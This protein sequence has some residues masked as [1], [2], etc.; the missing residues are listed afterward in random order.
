MRTRKPTA[1]LE[2]SGAFIKDPQRRRPPE[3]VPTAPLGGPPVHLDE[4]EQAIW[5]EL[6]AILPPGVAGNTDRP[7]FELVSCLLAQ[8]RHFRGTMSGSKQ[9]LLANLLGKF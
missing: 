3:P 7:T 8:F 4:R 5:R 1:I 2:A 6:A 9:S